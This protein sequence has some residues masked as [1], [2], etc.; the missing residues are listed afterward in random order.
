MKKLGSDSFY[1]H[2]GN[3]EDMYIVH[4]YALAHLVP[5]QVRDTCQIFQLLGLNMYK[6]E[7]INDNGGD[8]GITLA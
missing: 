1:G 8:K 5:K 2:K 7:N 6:I 4:I 3:R